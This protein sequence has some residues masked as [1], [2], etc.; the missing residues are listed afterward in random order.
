MGRQVDAEGF[1]SAMGKRQLVVQMQGIEYHC[2]AFCIGCHFFEKLYPLSRHLIRQVRYAGEILAWPGERRGHSRPHG[3]VADA[4]DDRY[5][6]LA[7]L[8]ERL[9]DVTSHREQHVGLLRHEFAGQFRKP[10]RHAIGV[11]VNDFD[12]AAIDKAALSER[13]LQR[14]IDRPQRGTAEHE[15]PD[16]EAAILRSCRGR[17]CQQSHKK[18]LG[19]ASFDHLV[20]AGEERGRDRETE[21]VRRPEIEDEIKP[22]WLLN[23]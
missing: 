12:V 17:C 1:S 4:A 9:D 22:S 10:R 16:P 5:A 6:A 20:G 15:P 11:P 7:C 19:D 2:N 13:V 3:V 18:R 21:R 8:E 23:R 14:L